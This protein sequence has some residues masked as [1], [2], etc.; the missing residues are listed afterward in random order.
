MTKA[1]FATLLGV[2]STVA[3]PG[4]AQQSAVPPLAA[5]G[6]VRTYFDALRRMDERAVGAVTVGRATVDTQDVID[7]IR[8]E[9][10]RN[11]VGV[12]LQLA[13]LFV[14]PLRD[15][16]ATRVEALFNLQVI[17]RKWFF[18][19]VA[20]ELRG[21]ATFYFTGPRDAARPKITDIKLDL[22]G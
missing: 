1:L 15:P 4:H 20:R 8:A 3:A 12:E 9:A 6:T 2:A 16:G 10:K 11:R 13:D 22:F 21:R 14:K 19:K 5:V 18:T 17:A 7:Q